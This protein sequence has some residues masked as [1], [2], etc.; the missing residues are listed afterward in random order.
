MAALRVV[1]HLDVIEDIPARCFPV[2]IGLSPDAL[3]LEQL[4]ETLGHCVIVTVSAPAHA[5][6]Q[7]VGLQERLPVV[8]AE[9]AALVRMNDDRLLRLPAPHRHQ[10]GVERQLPIH[11]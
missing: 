10:Q 11:A 2:A 5:G 7:V 6:N 8:T 1:E 9:L 4:E 3:P